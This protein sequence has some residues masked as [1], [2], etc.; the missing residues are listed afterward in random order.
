M[1]SSLG[2]LLRG[3]AYFH[4]KFE[5]GNADV[6]TTRLL[7]KKTICGSGRRSSEIVL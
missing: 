2:I 3:Y 6:F 5:K 7:L 4:E 1:E